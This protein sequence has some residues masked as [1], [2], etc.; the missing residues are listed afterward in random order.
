MVSLGLGD[1]RSAVARMPRCIP[2]GARS[3]V[4]WIAGY[5]RICLSN[6]HENMEKVMTNQQGTPDLAF[7]T[8]AEMLME[9]KKRFDA[10]VF[11]GMKDLDSKR[12]RYYTDWRGPEVSCLGLA[13]FLSTKIRRNLAAGDFAAEDDEEDEDNTTA[14]EDMGL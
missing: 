9:I 8:T 12:I 1:A 5:E 3:A 10:F 7:V 14:L 11:A 13:E 4:C 6:M 2:T